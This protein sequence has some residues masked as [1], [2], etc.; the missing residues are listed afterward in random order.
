MLI[1]YAKYA[2]L[3]WFFVGTNQGEMLLMQQI[4]HDKTLLNVT[5][6]TQNCLEMGNQV[7]A[8]RRQCREFG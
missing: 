1:F 7:G 4:S 6:C 3:F 2:F 5:A 8:P